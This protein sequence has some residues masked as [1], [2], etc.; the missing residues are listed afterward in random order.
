MS[1]IR[2]RQSQPVRVGIV[3]AIV[4]ATTVLVP[5]LASAV[6]GGP[7]RP[8]ATAIRSLALP[9]PGCFAATSPVLGWR[10][11]RC[12]AAPTAILAPHPSV[13]RSGDARART[14]PQKSH[15]GLLPSDG[16]PFVIGNTQD[17]VAQLPSPNSPP[18]QKAVGSFS[19]ESGGVT[20][21]DS[22]TTLP[23]DYTL[24]VNS[25]YFA[26]TPP[27]TGS[28]SG[29]CQGW[30]QFAY[31][32]NGNQLFIQY[33]LYNYNLGVTNPS[34]PTD[35]MPYDVSCY[36]NSATVDLSSLGLSAPLVGNLFAD[37]VTL[38]GLVDQ[39]GTCTTVGC[40]SST[41]TT[42]DEAVMTLQ[43]GQSAVAVGGPSNLLDLDASWTDAEFGVFGAGSGSQAVFSSGTQ[44]GVETG[45][46]NGTSFTPAC[47]IGGT[48]GETNNLSFSAPPTL[49]ANGGFGGYPT[50]ET[51]QDFTASGTAACA[52]GY[53]HGDTHE[54][55]FPYGNTLT[56]SFQGRGDY[57]DA[58]IGPQFTVEARQ[59]SAAPTWPNA[60][61]NQAIAALVG[62]TVVAVCTGPTRLV[63]AGHFLP[64]G[65]GRSYNLP[66]RADVTQVG[67]LPTPLF[68]IRDAHGNS[69]QVQVNYSGSFY[70]LD[71]KV[72]LGTWP[73]RVE[74]L[75]ASATGNLD[76][77]QGVNGVSYRFP[78]KF[79]TFY[80]VF[81]KGWVVPSH[82]D[83]LN[84]SCGKA[85]RYSTYGVPSNVL[86]GSNLKSTIYER[87][88]TVCLA[89]GVKQTAQL[90]ECTVDV[91]VLGDA[92]A[93]NYR[94]L[95]TP[96]FWGK[97][98]P[99]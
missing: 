69:V 58:T 93:R 4:I 54:Q 86:Y 51:E 99:P 66:N 64:L 29:A 23:N 11:V 70:Y 49:T 42:V 1:E 22:I 28:S 14:S 82:G 33:W 13:G 78:T 19:S 10:P 80:D 46:Y 30:E 75:L 76:E 98:S 41:P 87:A 44:L 17:Y 85:S 52:T 67:N 97:V 21:S 45:I 56:Y 74:G 36:R 79:K 24:Q 47:S 73:E 71:E 62:G 96:S 88:H 81:G 43:N 77:V 5:V 8:W 34:C 55:T 53:G 9:G 61:V 50:V 39:T 38:S 16:S 68:V 12:G 7:K 83:F 18:I 90:D 32:S 59:V 40:D 95:P 25:N 65:N 89:A 15:K 48:T 94:N 60:A 27:C 2:Q 91:A 37:Q 6:S 63:A 35:W 31:A 72:G 92:A 57:V 26:N 3:V 84:A 20:E